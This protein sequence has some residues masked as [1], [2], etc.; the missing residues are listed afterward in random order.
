MFSSADSGQYDA[1][2]ALADSI[3]SRCDDNP[4]CI[5]A[6]IRK[7]DP[8]TRSDLLM[9]DLLNAWQV[10]WY[11]FQEYPGDEAVEFLSFH[12][13]GELARSVPM[14]DI[15]IFTLTFQVI[16]GDPEIG[17]SD[18]VQEV[19]RFRGTAAWRDTKAYLDHEGK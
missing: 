5:A 15:G 19:A 17:I 12:A 13:A 10:F 6:E 11:H 18:D 2:S 4:A 7:L 3:F 1:L 16:E 8:D 14:G 9:S